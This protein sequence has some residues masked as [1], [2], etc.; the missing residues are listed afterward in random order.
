MSS[1]RNIYIL[2]CFML[3]TLHNAQPAHV[4]HS[5][6]QLFDDPKHNLGHDERVAIVGLW[7][8]TGHDLLHGGV[9]AGVVQFLESWHHGELFVVVILTLC[10][11]VAVYL[12]LLRGQTELH[13]TIVLSLAGCQR[14]VV[15]S[16]TRVEDDNIHIVLGQLSSHYIRDGKECALQMTILRLENNDTI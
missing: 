4:G 6:R 10:E 1:V 16:I 2:L 15:G 13:V 9:V 8:D 7:P 5:S 14:S 3:I 12:S 11:S